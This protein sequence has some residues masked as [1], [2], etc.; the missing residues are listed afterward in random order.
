[1]VHTISLAFRGLRQEDLQAR[2]V[3]ATKTV[4]TPAVD[5]QHPPSQKKKKK[6]KS[7]KLNDN[8]KEIFGDFLF[9]KNYRVN[10]SH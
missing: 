6:R 1:M 10:F 5:T 8:V 3:W 9:F 2:L 7:L 4:K